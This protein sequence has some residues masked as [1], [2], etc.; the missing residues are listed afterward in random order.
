MGM[1]N[2]LLDMVVDV[3]MDILQK[4]G[5][6]LDSAI[7]AEERHLAIYDELAQKYKVQYVAGGAVLN[8]VRVAQWMLGA[9]GATSYVGCV[10]VDSFGTEVRPQLQLTTLIMSTKK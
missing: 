9:P 3:D 5:V 10:G 6:Q 8:S 7:L 4:Y 1:G 2:P